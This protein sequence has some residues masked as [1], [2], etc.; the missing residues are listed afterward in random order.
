[1][2]PHSKITWL[3]I[4]TKNGVGCS[5]LLYDAS[6]ILAGLRGHFVAFTGGDREELEEK[7]GEGQEGR[8]RRGDVDSD[9]KLLPN[10]LNR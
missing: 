5:K 10:R 6:Q 9:A 4:S 2:T 7:G 3:Q 1:M 8:G